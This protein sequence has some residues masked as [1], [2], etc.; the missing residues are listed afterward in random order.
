MH[1]SLL[2]AL[3]GMPTVPDRCFC[4]ERH[5]VHGARCAGQPALDC[6]FSVMDS[7][8]ADVLDCLATVGELRY[9]TN[10][11]LTNSYAAGQ[12]WNDAEYS[13]IGAAFGSEPLRSR[14]LH[15]GVIDQ[16]ETGATESDAGVSKFGA[17]IGNMT[18]LR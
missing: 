6:G 17:G 10:L 11:T 3:A 4:D 8:F 13:Q 9:V 2:S 16:R 14:L 18:K 15:V 5:Q 7:S 1:L 12:E